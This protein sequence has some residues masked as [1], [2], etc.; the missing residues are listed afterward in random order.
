MLDLIVFAGLW[1]QF[2]TATHE[3]F[4]L[5]DVGPDGVAEPVVEVAPHL[6]PGPSERIQFD[7]AFGGRGVVSALLRRQHIER[8][9][10]PTLIGVLVLRAARL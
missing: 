6:A 3:A 8:A 10:A 2:G 4:D 7:G 1:V 5:V 9:A